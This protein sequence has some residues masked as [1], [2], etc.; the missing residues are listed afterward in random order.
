MYTKEEA[1][2][3]VNETIASSSPY[4][5]YHDEAKVERHYDY[6]STT[7]IKSGDNA[8]LLFFF[9][10][11]FS[12]PFAFISPWVT[13]IIFC[14]CFSLSVVAVLPLK[15]IGKKKYEAR[16]NSV[17]RKGP[18]NFTTITRKEKINIMAEMNDLFVQTVRDGKMSK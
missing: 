13:L 14:I 11:L 1:F 15:V 17:I 6:F 7:L 8:F 9:S 18:Y 5:S 2:E 3:K 16:G 4:V 10:M 12:T